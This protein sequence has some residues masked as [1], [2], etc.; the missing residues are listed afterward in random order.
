MIGFNTQPRGGGCA[1]KTD[2]VKV[3]QVST[4][5]RAEAAASKAVCTSVKFAV[6]TLSRAEAAA[7]GF[8]IFRAFVIVSTLSRAEAAAFGDN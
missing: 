3:G 4:L 6:S 2:T 8:T 7:N 5:S 1:P